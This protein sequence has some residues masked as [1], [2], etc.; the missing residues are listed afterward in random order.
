[1]ASM[2][3]MACGLPGS[4][5]LTCAAQQQRQQQCDPGVT[6]HD[7]FK[8]LPPRR[9]TITTTMQECDGCLLPSTGPVQSRHGPSATEDLG[10][11]PKTTSSEG[12]SLP[13]ATQHCSTTTPKRMHPGRAHCHGPH[14]SGRHTYL[15]SLPCVEAWGD[16]NLHRGH[17]HTYQS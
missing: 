5:A 6:K 1:M 12:Q 2:M 15:N 3:L 14:V 16:I 9:T 4:W 7:S 11:S 13:P 17:L 8:L 10:C